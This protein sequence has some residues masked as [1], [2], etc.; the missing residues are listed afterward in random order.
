MQKESAIES[1]YLALQN[2]P[3][4]MWKGKET[5]YTDLLENP[6]LSYE[7]YVAVYHAYY[8]KYNPLAADLYVQLIRTRKEIAKELGY[9]SYADFAYSYQ[10]KRDY[11]PEQV[12]AY[13]DDIADEMPSLLFPAYMAQ[14]ELPYVDV[15][16]SLSLFQ[17][18]VETFGGVIKTS[19]EFM[20]D[21]ELWDASIS[22]SKLPGSYMTY[23]NSY[24]MPFLYVSPDET[25]GDLMTLCHEF[26]HFVDGFVNCGGFSGIDC[27]EVFSQGLEFLALNRADLN[28]GD[29]A[30]LAKSKAADSVLVF[31]TQACYAE[32]EALAYELPDSKLNADGLNELY[33]Q[34]NE[35]YGTSLFYMGMETLLAPGWIDIQHFYVAPFYVISYCV[36]N[37]VA[38]QIYQQE[39]AE[40]NGLDLYYE[41]LS[42]DR[43]ST[44][45]ELT[46]NTE[47]QSPFAPGRIKAL[48]DFLDDQLN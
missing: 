40:G 38:L 15:E 34:C 27:A 17:D 9:A 22:S 31:L 44:I 26:G 32:F 14:M 35:K 18:V 6:K 43:E 1:Q 5:S 25:L 37:D 21:Y 13:C 36:S 29:R 23:L 3:T 45:L 19:Y 8:D 39:L 10:Y 4:I 24:E 46:D 11:S 48:A 20:K 42:M 28:P 33:A 30:T 7:E 47:L 2:D 12:A 41:L 16:D